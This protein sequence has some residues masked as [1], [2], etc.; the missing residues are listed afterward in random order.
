MIERA[1]LDYELDGHSVELCGGSE[2]LFPFLDHQLPLLEH[3]HEFH[4]SQG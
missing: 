4:P 3:V 1:P 2:D